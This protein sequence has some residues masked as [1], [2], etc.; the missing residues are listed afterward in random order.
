LNN[1][2]LKNTR[3]LAGFLC[4]VI[5]WIFP[6]SEGNSPDALQQ[7][8]I[9]GMLSATS[10]LFGLSVTTSLLS[11]AVAGGVILISSTPNPYIGVKVASVAGIFLTGLACHTGAQLQR[12]PD[13][14]PWLLFALVAAAFINAIEGLLQW[15]GLVGEL[16]HWV[17]EPEQRGIAFGALRQTN[18]F[19]TFLCVGAV[20]TVWLV[21]RLR[22]TE[23][24]AWFI[25]LILMFGVAASASRTGMLEVAA[26]AVLGLVWRKQ[27]RPAVT[28]LMTGQ[29]ILLALAI[30]ILPFAAELHGFGFSSGLA[31]AAQAGKDNRLAI[32]SNSIDMIFQRPWLGWGWHEMGYAHYVTL[33]DYRFNELLSHSHN[34]L[35][36]IALD[37]GLPIAIFISMVMIFLMGQ[38]WMRDKNK[39]FPFQGPAA[40][41][42]FAW[43]ILLLIVGIHSMLEYPLW[44]AGFLFLTGFFLGYLLPVNNYENSSSRYRTWSKCVNT[45][46]AVG[47]IGLAV[48]AW[49]QYA[50]VLPIYKTPFT[51]N[52]EIQRA[53]VATAIDHASQAWLFRDLL[54]FAELG[55]I[56][57]TPE[58]AMEVRQR[59]EKLLH[60]SAEPG[61]I[62]P[63]LLSLWFLRDTEALNFHAERFCRAFPSAF[64]RWREAYANHPIMLAAGQL[65]ERC[66]SM[67]P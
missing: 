17:I 38:P 25:L 28:R 50:T 16:Y 22:L 29:F 24:M 66:Q 33:F 67:A 11:L 65:T 30:F 62:Q 8:F 19:A 39:K 6:Y 14:L 52:R 48:V 3:F 59:A 2:V 64:Q 53:A 55:L 41:K 56:E 7:I 15:F 21:H 26:T 40:D 37:F 9:L 45:G 42:G 31:R 13:G 63:L 47:L 12:R 43:I 23:A 34:L 35:L 54:D 20:C 51:N 18:L 32:W 60:F 1:I 10:L 4:L 36:Q 27:H 57:V 58:N 49:H 61:V 46:S 5:A 44:Y